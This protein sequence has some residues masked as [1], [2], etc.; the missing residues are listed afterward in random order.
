MPSYLGHQ[1]RGS[2]RPRWGEGKPDMTERVG[3]QPPTA[4]RLL[5]VRTPMEIEFAPSGSRFAFTLQAV[6]SE[7]GV[8]QP[9]DLWMVERPA[10]F[11][12]SCSCTGGRRGAGTPCSPTRNRTRS[13]LLRPVTASC[14][15][16]REGARAGATRSPRP[17]SATAHVPVERAHLLDALQRTQAWFDRHLTTGGVGT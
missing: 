10:P 4:E 6:V 15:P 13:C 5:A 14:C 11:P 3:G 7:H 1:D 17:S 16:T 12:C 2:G 9:S 8:T